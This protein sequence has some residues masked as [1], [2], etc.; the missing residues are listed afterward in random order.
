MR[1]VVE[2]LG[3]NAFDQ[4]IAVRDALLNYSRLMEREGKLPE[5][6]AA[7]PAEENPA[8]SKKE[9]GGSE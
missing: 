4:T 9:T 5:V 8:E 6:Q 1:F 3:G 2:F 7:A